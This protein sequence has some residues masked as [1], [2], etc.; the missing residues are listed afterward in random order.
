MGPAVGAIALGAPAWL[1]ACYLHMLLQKSLILLGS[2]N[3]FHT[4]EQSA[5]C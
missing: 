3:I 1:R 2:G 4:S 5:T